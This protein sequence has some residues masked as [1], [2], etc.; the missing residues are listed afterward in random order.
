M[1]NKKVAIVTGGSKGIGFAVVKELPKTFDGD[2]YLTA[3]N[4]IRGRRT[5][6]SKY[7]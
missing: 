4:E 2:V 3:R 7:G 1:S 5:F 6:I